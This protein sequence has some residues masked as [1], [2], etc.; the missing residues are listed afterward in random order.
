LIYIKTNLISGL[1]K[2]VFEVVAVFIKYLF[3]ILKSLHLRL[4]F[5]ICL[6]GV[7]LELVFSK[8]SGNVTYLIVFLTL[9]G[10]ALV[11]FIFL[12][13]DNYFIKNIKI[14]KSEKIEKKEEI[15]KQYEEEIPPLTNI[16]T[17]QPQT[18]INKKP[19]YYRVSQNPQYIMAEYND[20]YELFYEGKNGLKY[21]RT[22]YKNNGEEYN[23]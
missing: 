1:I 18:K 4:L 2:L 6:A 23:E 7:F 22:D 12:N 10:F 11:R 17:I 21:I 13:F 14:E 3:K 15:T 8:L 20:R 5:I 9:A 19:F 16:K